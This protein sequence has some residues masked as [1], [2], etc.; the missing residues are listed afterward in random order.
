MQTRDSLKLLLLQIRQEQ[1][2]VPTGMSAF[3]LALEMMNHVGDIDAELRDK[4]IYSTLSRWSKNNEFTFEQLRCLLRFSLD[5]RHL[6]WGIGEVETDTVF[7]RS[8]SVL[9]VPLAVQ[10]H[11]RSSFLIENEIHCIKRTLMQYIELEQDLRGFVSGKGWAHAIAH[12]ADAL[13]AIA[14]SPFLKPDDL[15]DILH[16]IKK[17]ICI[18]RHAFIY[19]EDERLVTVVTTILRR[20]LLED[21]ISME[22]ISGLGVIKNSGILPDDDILRANTKCFL[23]SLYFRLMAQKDLGRFKDTVIESLKLL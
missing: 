8:F 17:K 3:E 16:I 19:N 4:L 7:T 9:L 10:V 1:Y 5:E 2:K 23:R 22:W 15:L 12:A 13:A 18:G 20:G 14:D 21:H 6:F 11:N